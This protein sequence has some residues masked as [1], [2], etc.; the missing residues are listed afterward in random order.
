[1]PCDPSESKE[2]KQAEQPNHPQCLETRRQERWGQ[3]D[4]GDLERVRP[5]PAPPSTD[6][7]QHDSGLDREGSPDYPVQDIRGGAPPSV[8]AGFLDHEDGYHEERRDELRYLE[9]SLDPERAFVQACFLGSAL[10][11]ST[12]TVLRFFAQDIGGVCR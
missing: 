5:D 1:M 3:H 4:D 11:R 10:L 2:R 9:C 7:R 12:P 8:Q 6:D